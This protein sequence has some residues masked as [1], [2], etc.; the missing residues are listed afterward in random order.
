MNEKMA[1]LL[2]ALRDATIEIRKGKNYEVKI[3]KKNKKWLE[4]IQ[5]IFEKEFGKKGKIS[6]HLNGYWILR[7]NGKEIVNQII[8]ISE[9]KIPQEN[10]N[11]PSIIKT[12]D[13][14]K[15]KINYIR[16]FFDSEGGLPKKITKNS[17]KYIIFSQK[18]KESLEFVKKVLQ[19]LNI[20]TTNLTKC[21]GVWEF[22]ITTK[23]DILKFIEQIGSLHPEKVRKLTII[24]R[25]LFSSI[26]RGST[27][28]VGVAVQLD[29][30]PGILPGQT[31]G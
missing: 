31:A 11:T 20:K 4:L 21:G 24:K 9:I 25:V 7:I 16:G 28:G 8:E 14:I 3:A 26:W 17:Q 15:T 13:N 29:S 6:K 1:Y 19:E 18:N 2:G 12:S 23:N 30:T 5:E 22:R 27:Q 10:W